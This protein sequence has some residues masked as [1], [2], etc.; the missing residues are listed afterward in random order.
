[1]PCDLCASGLQGLTA[2]RA[3]E[4][5]RREIL[6]L[7]PSALNV[8]AV[9]IDFFLYD[10]A[11]EREFSN[12]CKSM[13]HHLSPHISLELSIALC[14]LNY[15]HAPLLYAQDV[16][17]SASAVVGEDEIKGH[18]ILFGITKCRCFETVAKR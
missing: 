11:K 14:T 8:N 15:S 5:I 13:S 9:L 17:W 3:V 10:L 12:T 7:D 6:K 2:R 16:L 1:M 4:L 18:K